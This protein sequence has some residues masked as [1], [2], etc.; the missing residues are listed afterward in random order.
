MKIND[1][2]V[3]C[4]WGPCKQVGQEIEFLLTLYSL[5]REQKKRISCLGTAVIY[6]TQGFTDYNGISW[7]FLIRSSWQPGD[8]TLASTGVSAWQV[9]MQ[10]SHCFSTYVPLW[11]KVS[12]PDPCSLAPDHFLLPLSPQPQKYGSCLLGKQSFQL[13][14]TEE[15]NHL[16]DNRALTL[17]LHL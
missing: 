4:L 3:C 6:I 9:R 17:A 2:V 16:Q 12:S 15:Q 14:N 8:G 7:S 13:L 11:L 10:E 5:Q 1:F